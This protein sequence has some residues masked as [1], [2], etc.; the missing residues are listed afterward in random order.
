MEFLHVVLAPVGVLLRPKVAAAERKTKKYLLNV[1]STSCLIDLSNALEFLLCGVDHIDKVFAEFSMTNSNGERFWDQDHF[2]R[3]VSARL[4]GDDAMVAC[5]PLLWRIFVS[6]AFF[7]F[8]TPTTTL[9]EAEIDLQAFRRAFALLAMR[10]FEL[11]GAKQNGRPLV[12]KLETNYADKV[13]RLS[14]IIFRTLSQPSPESAPQEVH[15]FRDIKDTIE[16]T[17][18]IT[19]DSYPY[20]PKV[21]HEQFEVAAS[22]LARVEDER[23]AIR[24]SS[25]IL[26]KTDLG[27]LVQPLLLLAPQDRRWKD[28][29]FINETY[30]RSGDIQC[31]QMASSLEEAPTSTYLA[32][33]FVTS[34]FANSEESV[35]WEVFETWCSDC[36][37]LSKVFPHLN[38]PV[39]CL[40]SPRSSFFS[41]SSG[42]VY[43]PQYPPSLQ[44]ARMHPL[45]QPPPPILS[46]S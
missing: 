11:L 21:D 26:S 3:Y 32:P 8:S 38:T 25:Q 13:P 37:G 14:R 2:T 36:V 10:G 7:P 44:V 18:P 29:L 24:G 40:T 43:S 17:Q 42:Q 39:D 19:Y 30:Q 27:S 20:G 46:A 41:S 28:G 33:I 12:R 5:I 16:Y 34:Q 23:S 4:P 31:V 45:C 9:G 22:R 35:S 1:N 6:S 15:Q